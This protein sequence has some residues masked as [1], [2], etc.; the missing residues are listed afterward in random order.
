MLE[1]V[2]NMYECMHAYMFYAYT[3]MLQADQYIYI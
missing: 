1:S 3:Y 2:L